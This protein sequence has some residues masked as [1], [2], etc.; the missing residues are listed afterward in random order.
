MSGLNWLLDI[1]GL[2]VQVELVSTLEVLTP[3]LLFRRSGHHIVDQHGVDQ[4]VVGA[5]EDEG[6]VGYPGS[7]IDTLG[8]DEE[9]SAGRERDVTEDLADTEETE[10]RAQTVNQQLNQPALGLRLETS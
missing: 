10:G 4:R 6:E 3:G 1:S 7:G 5:P 9:G 2:K 8:G